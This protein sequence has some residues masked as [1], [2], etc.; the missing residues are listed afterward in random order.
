M[1]RAPRRIEAVSVVSALERAFEDAPSTERHEAV[2]AR[3]LYSDDLVAQA[4][5]EPGLAEQTH[6]QRSFGR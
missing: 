6:G 5:Q 1:D 3:V 2:R 4:H